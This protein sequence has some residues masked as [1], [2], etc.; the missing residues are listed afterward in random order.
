M[1][2]YGKINDAF[3]VKWLPVEEEIQ[4]N[5]TKVAFKGLCPPLNTFQTLFQKKNDKWNIII[6]M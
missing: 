5:M 6:A 3:S 4:I 1:N 2:D